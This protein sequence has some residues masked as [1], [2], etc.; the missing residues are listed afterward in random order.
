MPP[1][2]MNTRAL[3]AC[4]ASRANG[5]PSAFVQVPP[6]REHARF[7]GRA[8]EALRKL[9]LQLQAFVTA[10]TFALTALSASMRPDADSA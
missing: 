7:P 3:A 8:P 2:A 4:S 5:A 10:L 9:V 6:H 1:S